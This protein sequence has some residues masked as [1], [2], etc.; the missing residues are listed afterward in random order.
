MHGASVRRVRPLET[1]KRENRC[2][3]GPHPTVPLSAWYFLRARAICFGKV[4]LQDMSLQA[5]VTPDRAVLAG[6]LVTAAVYCRDLQYDFIL[7]DVPLILVNQTI[8]SWTNWKAVLLSQIFP[9]ENGPVIGIHYRPVYVFWLMLNE[10]LFGLVVPWWHLTSILVHLL[11]IFLVYRV[12]IV[13]LK[14][15]WTA[16]LAAL[17]HAAAARGSSRTVSAHRHVSQLLRAESR[18]LGHQGRP[19]KAVRQSP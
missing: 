15:R 7:D 17:L 19:A 14:V 18:V 5:R 6:M 13:I 2:Q 12:G 9:T 10:H 1:A 3:D 11:A 4:E 16:A 8:L